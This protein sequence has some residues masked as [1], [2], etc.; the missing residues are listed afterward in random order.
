[1]NGDAVPSFRCIRTGV[2][3]GHIRL[4]N[5]PEALVICTFLFEIVCQQIHIHL[6]LEQGHA[7]P[8]QFINIFGCF[9]IE[10]KGRKND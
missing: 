4:T 5:Q 6:R 9:G 1:M 7:R 3:Y 8:V 10:L 2:F